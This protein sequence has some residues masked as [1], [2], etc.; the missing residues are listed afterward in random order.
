MQLQ[1]VSALLVFSAALGSLLSLPFEA[2]WL[3]PGAEGPVVQPPSPSPTP[4]PC[5]CSESLAGGR[6]ESRQ[7]GS[8]RSGRY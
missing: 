1:T 5:T 6:L 4:G 3:Q 8:Q 7:T 2:A